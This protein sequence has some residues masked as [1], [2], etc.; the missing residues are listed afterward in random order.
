MLYMLFLQL[1]GSRAQGMT[2]TG[3]VYYGEDHRVPIAAGA[4]GEEFREL[5]EGVIG[6][7]RTRY[8][9]PFK[10]LLSVSQPVFGLARYIIACGIGFQ[11]GGSSWTT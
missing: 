4:A 1:Q 3:E 11:Q 7:Y 5:V 8:P 9:G 10:G 2:V 6:N